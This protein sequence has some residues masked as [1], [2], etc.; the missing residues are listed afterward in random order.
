M[1]GRVRLIIYSTN[2]IRLRDVTRRGVMA[3]YTTTVNSKLFIFLIG[4]RYI[5]VNKGV[6]CL[7]INY[8]RIKSYNVL[9]YRYNNCSTEWSFPLIFVLVI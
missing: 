2:K 9:N 4:Y 1:L 5:N 6:F 7:I 3:A 8:L